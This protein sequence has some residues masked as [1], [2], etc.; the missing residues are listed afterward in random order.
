M[1]RRSS[2]RTGSFPAS[3]LRE[4]SRPKRVADACCEG[5]PGAITGDVN[6]GKASGPRYTMDNQGGRRCTLPINQQHQHLAC[7]RVRAVMWAAAAVMGGSCV[8]EIE[9]L[10]HLEPGRGQRLLDI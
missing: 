5:T 3:V 1:A 7:A 6:Q 9:G 2:G 4:C 8:L 10:L